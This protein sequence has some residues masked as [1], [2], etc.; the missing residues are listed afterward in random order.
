VGAWRRLRGREPKP[1]RACEPG[2]RQS[3]ARDPLKE[4]IKLAAVDP[5]ALHDEGD[6][7]IVNQLGEQ[8]PGDVHDI[9]PG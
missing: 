5:V 7:G 9:S 6:Q 4:E 3:L 2:R 1:T 8:A